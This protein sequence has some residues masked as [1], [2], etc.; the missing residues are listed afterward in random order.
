[1]Y[2]VDHQPPGDCRVNV[3]SFYVKHITALGSS[4]SCFKCVMFDLKTSVWFQEGLYHKN[5]VL[6]QV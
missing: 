2:D 3:I 4:R 5:F 6:K 1:M